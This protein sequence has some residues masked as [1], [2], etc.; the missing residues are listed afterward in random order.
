M[1]G[2]TGRKQLGEQ[3]GHEISLVVKIKEN[4]KSFNRHIRSKRFAKERV[5]ALGDQI[6]IYVWSLGCGQGPK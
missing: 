3:R 1:P 4:P 2:K 5:C 6:V